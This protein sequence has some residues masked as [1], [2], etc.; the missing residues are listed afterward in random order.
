MNQTPPTFQTS[1]ALNDRVI[2][3]DQQD[4]QIGVM[5][6]TQAHC[7]PAH[8]HRASSVFL[9]NFKNQLLIQQRS[10]KKIVGANQWANT[11]CGNLRPGEN[12]QKC[13]Q[14][15]LKEELGITGVK[16]TKVTKFYYQVKCNKKYGEHEIDTLF[17]GYYDG[18][19]KPNPAEV[20]DFMWVS[21]KKFEKQIVDL[22]NSHHFTPW[23]SLIYQQLINFK[24]TM[25]S[26]NHFAKHQPPCQASPTTSTNHQRQA[27]PTAIS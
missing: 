18:L 16:L 20:S 26:I 14:R 24:N 2:L 6:K 3:V 17:V 11:C 5:D 10:H 7:N 23:T 22:A 19:I 12:Y 25:P 1:P 15:R 13:A 4:N 8:L 21:P 9:Y 27:S